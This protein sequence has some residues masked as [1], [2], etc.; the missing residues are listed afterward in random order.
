MYVGQNRAQEEQGFV[1][2][3]PHLK[4]LSD[5]WYDEVELF[6]GTDI[7]HYKFKEK[8][9]HYSQLV[10]ATTKEVGCGFIQFQWKKDT[11]S[12]VDNVL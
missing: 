9:G 4:V 7:K 3:P 6:P 11:K 1:A 5:L 2:V 10:W 8:W 12:Q